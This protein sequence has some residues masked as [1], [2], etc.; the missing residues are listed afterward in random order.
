MSLYN[1]HAFPTIQIFHPAVNAPYYLTRRVACC[2][3]G[4]M[5][6]QGYSKYDTKISSHDSVHTND[7]IPQCCPVD[8]QITY[9][10]EHL[11]A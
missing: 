2:H 5:H 8:E 4:L 9:R 3:R 7:Q 10:Q 6:L 1:Q 11:N